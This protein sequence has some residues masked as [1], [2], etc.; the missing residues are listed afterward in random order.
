[1][2]HLHAHGQSGDDTEEEEEASPADVEELFNTDDETESSANK[3]TTS[4]LPLMDVEAMIRKVCLYTCT[5]L[6]L[7]NVCR[8]AYM[9]V[10]EHYIYT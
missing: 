9:H 1:M 2:L 3:N 7:R 4:E 8:H 5:F 6:C 10:Y